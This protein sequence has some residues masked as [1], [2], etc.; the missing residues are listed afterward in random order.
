MFFRRQKPHQHTFAERL[1]MIE[2]AGFTVQEEGDGKAAV[3]RDG[4]VA[5]IEDAPGG[6]PKISKA[7]FVVGREIA[8]LL[9][10]GYQKMWR[11]PG[12]QREPVQ[13]AHLKA[14]H[15]LQEDLRETL[16]LTSLYNESLG[17]VSDVH[18]YD[19]VAGGE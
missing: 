8:E 6:Q 9:E 2:E 7:G 18:A 15:A 13:A 19:R 11:T 16:G 17:T 14:L 5:L 12:G 4:C 1:E 10:L 3:S